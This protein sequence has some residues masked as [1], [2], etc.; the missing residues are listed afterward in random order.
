MCNVDCAKEKTTK[1]PRVLTEAEVI[2]CRLYL[3]DLDG[4]KTCNEYQILQGLL[5]GEIVVGRTSNKETP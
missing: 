4:H 2:I 3:D 1:E 5:N